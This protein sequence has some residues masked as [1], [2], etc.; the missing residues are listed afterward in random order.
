[1]CKKLE[2]FTELDRTKDEQHIDWRNARPLRDTVDVAKLM[3]W[4]EIHKP[5]EER[6]VIVSIATGIS[7]N[8]V[9]LCSHE[10]YKVGNQSM[11]QMIGK[12]YVDA[13]L[14][15]MNIISSIATLKCLIKVHPQRKGKPIDPLAR[16]QRI[17]LPSLCKTVLRKY[18]AFELAPFAMAL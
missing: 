10:A 2:S 1:M 15:K 16:F 17:C 9:K 11:K 4:L 18:F 6:D 5:F 3:M 12:N 8:P 14:K 7:G 13:K